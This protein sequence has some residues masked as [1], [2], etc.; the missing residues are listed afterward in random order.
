VFYH[1]VP[2]EGMWTAGRVAGDAIQLPTTEGALIEF[3]GESDTSLA[4]M[5]NFFVRRPKQLARIVTR[6]TVW[7]D[8]ILIALSF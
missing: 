5:F 7:M 8:A 2:F 4:Q 3:M 6:G 1:I